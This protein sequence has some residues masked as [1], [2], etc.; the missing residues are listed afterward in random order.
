RFGRVAEI[1]LGS[2]LFQ[3]HGRILTLRIGRMLVEFS[4][5]F[6]FPNS[7]WE[8]AVRETPFRASQQIKGERNRVSQA[9]RSQTEFG[10]ERQHPRPESRS[11]FWPF[12]FALARPFVGP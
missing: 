5:E 4:F 3:R 1:T 9:V 6:S 11:S 2:V 8:R 12:P 10:N 7:V